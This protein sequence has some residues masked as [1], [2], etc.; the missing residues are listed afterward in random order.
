MHLNTDICDFQLTFRLDLKFILGISILHTKVLLLFMQIYPRYK[1]FPDR[2]MAQSHGTRIGGRTKSPVSDVCT[3]VIFPFSFP[4]AK[5]IGKN[6][7]IS[8]S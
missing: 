4:E 1:C 7:Q 8:Q 6:F 3:Y 5:T 2:H